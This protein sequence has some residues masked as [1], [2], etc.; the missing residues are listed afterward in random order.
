MPPV[1]P[2]RRSLAA[3]LVLSAVVT[4]GGLVPGLGGTQRTAEA[5]PVPPPAGWVEHLNQMRAD[6]GSGPVTADVGLSSAAQ[7]HALYMAQH[8]SLTRDQDPSRSRHTPAG[9]AAARHSLLAGPAGNSEDSPAEFVD[10]WARGAFSALALLHPDVKRIGYG[11]A[12]LG[13]A[14]YAA[15]D[16]RSAR[17]AR[18][19]STGWP[20]TWPSARR[21]VGMT[22]Y[23]GAEMPDPLARCGPRPSRGWGLPLLVSYGPGARPTGSAAS[24]SVDGRAVSVCVVAAHGNP[25]AAAVARLDEAHSVVVVPREPLRP[26]GTYTGAVTSSRG[27]AALRFSVAADAATGSVAT[28]PAPK[29]S[30]APSLW[31]RLPGAARDLGVGADGT[32][33]VLGRSAV[34]GGWSI[35]RW[36]GTRWA[37]VPGGAVSLD[38][39]GAGQAWIVHSAAAVYRG[40]VPG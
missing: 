2:S 19:Q 40:T 7:Q 6:Y 17:A 3:V 4:A 35:H 33:W 25:D 32:A 12:Q 34:P 30:S 31:Q 13:A 29:P 28:A 26:G 11:Q 8:R 38:V 10:L 16:V 5:A 15:L 37:T 39:D 9:R 18:A 14:D 23:S 24:L 22:S 27:R 36:T 20:R 1:F 21:P